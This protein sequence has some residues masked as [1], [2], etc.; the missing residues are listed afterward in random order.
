MI[1]QGAI[2]LI[3]AAVLLEC[4]QC[5]QVLSLLALLVQKHIPQGAIRLIQAAVLLECTKSAVASASQ[6]FAVVEALRYSV[7]LLY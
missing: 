7:Y 2:S 1:P 4:A 5:T 3:Q 6:L